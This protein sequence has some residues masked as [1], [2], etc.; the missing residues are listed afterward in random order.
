MIKRIGF[1]L[2][3]CWALAWAYSQ[4]VRPAVELD[5]SIRLWGYELRFGVLLEVAE[6]TA[7]DE[8]IAPADTLGLAATTTAAELP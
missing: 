1:V 4:G 2:M 8:T 5:H 7:P 6:A 3:V